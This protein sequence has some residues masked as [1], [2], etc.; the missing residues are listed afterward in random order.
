[1][2]PVL[3]WQTKCQ[4]V[5]KCKTLKRKTKFKKPRAQPQAQPQAQPRAQPQPQAQA[6]DR[7]QDMVRPQTQE[8]Q[9]ISCNSE[10]CRYVRSGGS[11]R[12]LSCY[13][14]RILLPDQKPFILL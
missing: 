13:D 14:H 5:G 9:C 12:Y 6:P 1:M 3:K 11:L 8:V 2:I 10:S 7:I 4:K